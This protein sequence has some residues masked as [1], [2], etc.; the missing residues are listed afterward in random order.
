MRQ[1]VILAPLLLASACLVVGCGPRN[2][3]PGECWHDIGVS[4]VEPVGKLIERGKISP[5]VS[6]LIPSDSDVPPAGDS[7]LYRAVDEDECKCLAATNAPLANLVDLEGELA[8]C[9]AS[10]HGRSKGYAACIQRELLAYRAA[11]QRNRAAADAL[12]LFFHLAEAEHNRDSLSRSLEEMERM[13]DNVARLKSLGME[14][15]IDE[16]ELYR[17]QT[18]LL[19][20]EATLLLSIEKINGQL[21]QCLGLDVEDATPIWP[22]AELK[23]VAQKID[24]DDAV[25]QAMVMRPDLGAL[26]LITENLDGNTLPAARSTLRAMDTLLGLS[27]SKL[28]AI[29]MLL[30]GSHDTEWA[31][32]QDQLNRLYIDQQRAVAAEVRR[33][34]LTVKTRLRQVTLAKE[35]LD[36]QQKRLKDRQALWGDEDV[37][38]FEIAEARL[39]VIQAQ[40]DLVHQVVAWKIA[41]AK[42]KEAQGLLAFECGFSEP[43]DCAEQTGYEFVAPAAA[44]GNSLTPV[45]LPTETFDSGLSQPQSVFEDGGG[46]DGGD[47]PN[48][49]RLDGDGGSDDADSEAD[50]SYEDIEVPPP[51]VQFSCTRSRMTVHDLSYS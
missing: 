38:P 8:I 19:D 48:G 36:N 5:D 34:V 16:S 6:E 10:G 2:C 41:C 13:R 25:A 28:P 33:A 21:K 14:T 11:A 42:L 15:G 30:C 40:S 32:R 35:Q 29:C 45:P 20:R 44:G 50:E 23:V 7:S 47:S 9:A 1:A 24:I 31:T 22:S 3:C 39:S 18:A 12:E 17:R 27:S 4:E 26:Q 51:P 43:P 46:L 37:T 49:G